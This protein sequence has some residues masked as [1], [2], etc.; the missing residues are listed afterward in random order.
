MSLKP[1]NPTNRIRKNEIQV[2]HGVGDKMTIFYS[3]RFLTLNFNL[4]LQESQRVIE[5]QS[6]TV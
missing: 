6:P 3:S 2:P 1:K 5:L 4:L